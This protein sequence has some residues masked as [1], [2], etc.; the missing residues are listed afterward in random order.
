MHD[1]WLL[2]RLP[3]LAEN[4]DNYR[5]MDIQSLTKLGGEEEDEEEEEEEEEDS[6]VVSS[7]IKQLQRALSVISLEGI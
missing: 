3:H 2:H 7:G 4:G 6:G 1:L 5:T